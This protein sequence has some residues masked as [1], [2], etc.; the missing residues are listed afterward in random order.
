MHIEEITII[1]PKIISFFFFF[2]PVIAAPAGREQGA[3]VPK[4]EAKDT[5]AV[6]NLSQ[7]HFSQREAFKRADHQDLTWIYS[8]LMC[9][10]PHCRSPAVHTI[11][12]VITI[13]QPKQGFWSL[14]NFVED[15]EGGFSV[16]QINGQFKDN[17]EGA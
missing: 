10:L 7:K 16:V 14:K 5:E 11:L 15:P 2:F 17:K 1:F 12:V 8:K 3:M 4:L 6:L 9:Q 13:N